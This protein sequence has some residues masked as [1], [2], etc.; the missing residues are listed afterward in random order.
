MLFLINL[1]KKTF[2]QRGKNKEAKKS[3]KYGSG[4]VIGFESIGVASALVLFVASLYK[5]NQMKQKMNHI[6]P[7]FVHGNEVL[8]LEITL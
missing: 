2:I 8:V 7:T 3:P 6:M 4:M 1:L 5:C